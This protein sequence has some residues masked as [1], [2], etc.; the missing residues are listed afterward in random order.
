VGL[1]LV[2]KRLKV[3]VDVVLGLREEQLISC[4]PVASVVAPDP[5]LQTSYD[6]YF[7]Y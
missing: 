3:L 4:L 7:P 6:D 5:Y 2:R 1:E